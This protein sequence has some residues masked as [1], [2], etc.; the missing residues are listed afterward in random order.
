M[1]VFDQY[2]ICNHSDG[3][4]RYAYKVYCSLVPRRDRRALINFLA[5]V[6]TFND[7]RIFIASESYDVE[8]FHIRVYALR[9]LLQSLA[10]LIG[11]ELEL[12]TSV[13][14]GWPENAPKEKIEEWRKKG[15]EHTKEEMEILVQETSG[16]EY[17]KLMR[18]VRIND[19]S[20]PIN[21]SLNVTYNFQRLGLRRTDDADESI[22]S[23]PLLSL[24][25]DHR[26]D[27]HS[28]FRHLASF[29]AS[30][31]QPENKPALDEFISGI[32][33]L[34]PEPNLLDRQRATG[35]WKNWL[36]VYAERIDSEREEWTKGRPNIDVDAE[37]EKEARGANPRF[38][39]R[40][41]VLEEVIKAVEKDAESGKR[42]L[43]K[44]LQ[45]GKMVLVWCVHVGN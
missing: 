11:A 16:L 26:L 43:R 28:T 38:V 36:A 8:N 9:S 44:V 20:A 24:M 29:K 32:L 14:P 2:H 3:E 30:L 41:W 17:G 33:A 31:I 18:R 12:G 1:D 40:Q 22:L 21:V 35:E 13:P 39:L 10:P 42:I 34:T 37:R 45:V 4:G 27:F 19:L 25:G 5:T 15:I 7:V 23:R 6:T